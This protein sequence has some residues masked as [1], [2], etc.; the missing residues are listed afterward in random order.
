MFNSAFD[1]ITGNDADYWP[2]AQREAIEEV[3][4]D[5]YHHINNGVYTSW[6]ASAARLMKTR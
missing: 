6:F 1:Q 5:I 3:N 2:A 4:A